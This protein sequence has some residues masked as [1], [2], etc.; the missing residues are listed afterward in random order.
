MRI[1]S[2]FVS[3]LLLGFS[4]FPADG[5]GPAEP[6][7][8]Y[9][10]I[11]NSDANNM[12]QY[13]KPPMRPADL[14]P[15]VDE[16]AEAG[17]TTLYMCPNYG[18]AVNYPSEITEMIGTGLKAEQ[19]VR[20]AKV[21][22]ERP[23]LERGVMN[24][25]SLVAAGH[26]P[27]GLV[28]DRARAKGLE[29][30]ITFRL[31]EVHWVDKPDEFPINLLLSK[32]WRE[33]PQ[34]RIGQPG[35]PLSQLHRDIL[36]PR[37]SPVVARWLPGGLNFAVPEVRA[38]RLAQLRE[39]CQRFDIDGLD[40]DFQ[41]F[42]MYFR[43]GEE[44]ANLKT[45]TAWIADVREMIRAVAKKRGR[46]I[47]LSV[48]VMARPEQ[49]LGLGLD[50]FDWAKRGL[51]DIVIVS[52]YLHNNFPLPIGEYRKRLPE[53]VPIYGSIEV[54]RK[55]NDYRR[56]AKRLWQ[57]GVDGI[58]MFNFFTCRDRGIEPEFGLLKELRNPKKIGPVGSEASD[59]RQ[60]HFEAQTDDN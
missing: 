12:F 16:I 13:V 2:L 7:R 32:F 25:K 14:Y 21:A 26:D 22:Q 52:H 24:L 5:G 11:Y 56:I 40:L 31:N 4:W 60:S 49:S 15:Y 17:V 37:T 42:P 1:L 27:L 54:E 50:P 9:R 10:L 30:F 55:A 41:R 8:R 47:L 44:A 3:A 18:M 59:G 29:T 19:E 38:R 45:M 48:R 34:W 57:D 39:C 46:P 36:G 6:G 33:H 58:M 53:H 43:P 23:S 20:V 51:I 28:I 35:D